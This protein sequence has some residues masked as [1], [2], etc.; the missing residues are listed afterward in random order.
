MYIDS[1][2]SY[3]RCEVEGPWKGGQPK[4][5][6]GS[7]TEMTSVLLEGAKE[8]S[9]LSNGVVIDLGQSVKKSKHIKIVQVCNLLSNGGPV[10]WVSSI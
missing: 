6:L 7:K 1:S 5:P 9:I 10:V 2:G 8:I 4:M 3:L